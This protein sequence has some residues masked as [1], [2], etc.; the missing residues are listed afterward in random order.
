MFQV[1]ARDTFTE[2][3]GKNIFLFFAN[4]KHLQD[5]SQTDVYSRR[6]FN[7]NGIMAV[8]MQTG[9]QSRYF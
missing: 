7:L 3:S 8:E 4:L 9:E 5:C 6:P 2:V 1:G